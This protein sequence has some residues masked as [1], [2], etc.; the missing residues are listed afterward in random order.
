MEPSPKPIKNWDPDD[1]ELGMTVEDS[2]DVLGIPHERWDFPVYQRVDYTPRPYPT[3]LEPTTFSLD[4]KARPD[5]ERTTRLLVKAVVVLTIF[6]TV[7]TLL[8]LYVLI[9]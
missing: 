9:A 6:M 8:V 4:P 7:L 5:V 3:M 1:I 2:E